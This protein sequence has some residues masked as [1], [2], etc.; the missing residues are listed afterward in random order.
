MTTKS[1]VELKYTSDHTLTHF[2]ARSFRLVCNDSLDFRLRDTHLFRM[3][4][5]KHPKL[6]YSIA[7]MIVER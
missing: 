6:L 7:E 3:R 1:E 2:Q 4:L 5:R